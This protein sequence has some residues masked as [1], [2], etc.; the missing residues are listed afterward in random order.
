MAHPPNRAFAAFRLN[1][2]LVLLLEKLNR[3]SAYGCGV[4]SVWSIP[5]TSHS[6]A[7]TSSIA[8]R[9]FD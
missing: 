9:M 7:P 4:F 6:G 8:I 2:V 5:A 3:P 1:F